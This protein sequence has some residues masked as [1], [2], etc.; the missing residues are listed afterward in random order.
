MLFPLKPVS[1]WNKQAGAAMDQRRRDDARYG[2]GK[3]DE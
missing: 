1:L 3:G 2:F